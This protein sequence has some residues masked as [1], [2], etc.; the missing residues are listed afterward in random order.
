MKTEF[1]IT[2]SRQE[3]LEIS[4]DTPFES[5][6]EKVEQGYGDGFIFEENDE[7][8]FAKKGTMLSANS[9]PKLNMTIIHFL[10]NHLYKSG[11]SNFGTRTYNN[12]HAFS[13]VFQRER[14]TVPTLGDLLSMQRIQLLR[15]RG[16]GEG[17]YLFLKA[18]LEK[19]GIETNNYTLFRT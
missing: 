7:G 2:A 18:E 14:N 13:S 16:I 10:D 15:M 3:M 8:F 11:V 19:I 12:L 4:A 6:K 9:L 17:S 1:T 5:F